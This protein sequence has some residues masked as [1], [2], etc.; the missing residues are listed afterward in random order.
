M[1][2]YPVEPAVLLPYLPRQLELDCWHGKTYLTLVGFVFR[3]A[4]LF[5][6]RIPFHQCFPEVNLRF[7]V[8]RRDEHGERRGL[9][10]LREIAPRWLVGVVARSVYNESYLTLPMRH[11]I[12]MSANAGQRSTFQCDWRFQKRWNR[13]RVETFGSPWPARAGSLDEFIVDH[14]WAYTRGTY[15]G[16]TEYQVDHPAWPIRRAAH[17]E[18]DWA[19]R[20]LYGDR[21]GAA[22]EGEP[23]SAFVAEGSLVAV[24]RGVEVG[25]T[26]APKSI[27]IGRSE[28]AREFITGR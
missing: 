1:L 24:H 22:I 14:Y 10:F 20:Q 12:D 4:R 2:S 27:E 11:S 15:G 25:E 21:L 28:F 23:E 9:I 18:L 5:G 8:V 19:T 17:V 26:H 7:Y 13:L 16:C 6:V 3:R